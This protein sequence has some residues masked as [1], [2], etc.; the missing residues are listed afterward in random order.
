MTFVFVHSILIILCP[1]IYYVFLNK[2]VPI[3][4]LKKKY[5]YHYIVITNLTAAH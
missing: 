2:I 1:F 3:L 5:I 4:L